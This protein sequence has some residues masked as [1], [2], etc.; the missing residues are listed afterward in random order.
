MATQWSPEDWARLGTRIREAREMQGLSR[1]ALAEMT[2]VS[3]KSIQIIEE[4]RVPTRWP[5]SLDAIETGIRWKPGSMSR[6][7][8]DG[9]PEPLPEHAPL[10][11]LE[12]MDNGTMPAHGA[13]WF[14]LSRHG[15]S[16]R[17]EVPGVAAPDYPPEI[18]QA[19]PFIMFFG[20]NCVAHGAPE[21]LGAAY[22]NAVAALLQS[23]TAP[24]PEYQPLVKSSRSGKYG[25]D[26]M[27]RLN[28]SFQAATQKL[29]EQSRVQQEITRR[30]LQPSALKVSQQ[31]AQQGKDLRELT[32]SGPAPMSALMELQKN[33]KE[34]A[35]SLSVVPTSEGMPEQGGEPPARDF[36]AVGRALKEARLSAGLSV[37]GL[38][39]DT[40]IHPTAVQNMER[41]DFEHM[42]AAEAEESKPN[43]YAHAHIQ[44]FAQVVGLDSKQ[45]VE[46]YDAAA[47]GDT[48]KKSAAPRRVVRRKKKSE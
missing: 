10:P 24:R 6:V 18:E 41:G 34:L 35:D 44:R 46:Q 36:S 40:G 28:K 25:Y 19:L 4:G 43:R 16:G 30:A 13:A 37:E 9:E 48:E 33:L 5:K 31:L 17:A 7:L 42:R 21:W 1:R 22:D 11:G 29:V 45:L 8:D 15:G 38:A 47:L 27:A 14:D 20:S 32:A 26:E 39:A 12:G 2:D 23:L 3:E